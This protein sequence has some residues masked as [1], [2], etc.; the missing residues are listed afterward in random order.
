MPRDYK[1]H[2]NRRRHRE[3]L[4]GW[5]W[6]LT[7]LLLGLLVA[8]LLYLKDLE[9]PR[10]AARVEA[11]P[12]ARV[13]ATPEPEPEP[14]TIPPPPKPKFDFYRILPEMEVVVPETEI[15]GK[16]KKG[17]PQVEKPGIYILQV[18][19]F[20]E[21]G[22]ADELRAR[23]ALLG[24]ESAV[25]KVTGADGHT[26]HRVRVGPFHDLHALNEARGRLRRHD[27]EAILLKLSKR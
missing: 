15:T 5:L 1:H 4:P 14:D 20:R 10:P 25:Q 26:W 3:P 12:T 18:G 2:A 17:V 16:P 8:W 19:S 7:G 6:L 24:F 22:K 9:P 21:A 13:A 27:L 11:P 23:L